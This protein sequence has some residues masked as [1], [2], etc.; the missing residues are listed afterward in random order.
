MHLIY[1]PAIWA[2]DAQPAEPPRAIL[3]TAPTQTSTN[4]LR[5][6]DRVY[7]ERIEILDNTIF[8][9]EELAT[10]T[11]PF[12]G[13]QLTFEDL[14]ELRTQINLYYLSKGF[15]NSGVVLPAQKIDDG[16]VTFR[17]IEGRITAIDIVE[18]GRLKPTFIEKR[19][20]LG[21]GPP[22]NLNDLQE[23]LQIMDTNPLIKRLDVQLS[24][25]DNPGEAALKVNVEEEKP[26]YVALSF[27]NNRSPAVGAEVLEL[28][29]AHN[30]V[31]GRGDSLS[32]LFGINE[33]IFDIALNYTVPI[34]A[35][36]TLLSFFY[37]D[38][39]SEVVE[40]PFDEID[41]ESDEIHY[42]VSLNHPFINNTRN[43]LRIGL[44]LEKIDYETKLFGRPF[45]FSQGV[46]GGKSDLTVVR[47][48]QEWIS[49]S[50]T[51]VTAF[52]SV[53]S[54]GIDAL[55]ADN[56]E[57]Y[58]DFF[59]WLGQ[60]QWT[61][62]LPK[63]LG[64]QI[65]VRGDLQLTDD[66]LLPYEKFSIGGISSVRG[67]REDELVRDKGAFG[68]LEYRHPIFNLA[69]PKVSKTKDDGKL[70]LVLFTDWGWGEN[71]DLPTPDPSYIYSAGA[72]L[73][74]H[75]SEKLFGEIY[76]AHGFKDTDNLGDDDLQDDGIHFNLK[77]QIF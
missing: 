42:G 22:L 64:G 13:R 56:N 7:I 72:G 48:S 40:D 51:Q 36:D 77:W 18:Y 2:Q 12:T 62:I 60:F 50:S 29:V 73:R 24:P 47:L 5:T 69:V 33:G 65:L 68:S 32:G 46:E 37:S 44:L 66:P 19:I 1:S 61:R 26:Y 11:G 15:I 8:S 71:N 59:M 43:Q 16:L 28:E 4:E 63:P 39:D 67:Y 54:F 21:T 30:N 70:Y 9:E 49:R 75:P 31:S 17:A 57:P 45:S 14:E 52:S 27:S 38:S 10:I 53:F 3:P 76:F 35:R 55:G 74:W 25:G 6:I 20:A 34:T 41:I 23:R 58:T